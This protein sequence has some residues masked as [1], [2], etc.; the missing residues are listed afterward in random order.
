MKTH[1]STVQVYYQDTDAEGIVYHANYLL[2]AER[3]RTQLLNSLGLDNSFF[4][5]KDIIFIIRQVC[6]DYKQPALLDD[7]L[8]IETSVEKIEH[9]RMRIKHRFL[10]QEQELVTMTMTVAFVNPHT[11]KPTVLPKEVVSLFKDYEGE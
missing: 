7:V 4:L 11:L 5:K 10:R 8:T 2:F 3:A 9:V 1:S 6:I